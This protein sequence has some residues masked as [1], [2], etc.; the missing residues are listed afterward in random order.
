MALFLL[1]FLFSFHKS[2]HYFLFKHWF[3]NHL[4][5]YLYL[6]LSVSVHYLF[7]YG[8][9]WF[10]DYYGDFY[11]FDSLN[12]YRLLGIL[13]LFKTF[14]LS[15]QIVLVD[16]VLT[17]HSEYLSKL[18]DKFLMFFV[19][20]IHWLFK[21]NSDL[22]LTWASTGIVNA[23]ITAIGLKREVGFFQADIR[24]KH[25]K[26]RVKRLDNLLLLSYYW[27]HSIVFVNG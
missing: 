4:F 23:Y 2:F 27:N 7:N 1:F 13:L 20:L 10:F 25:E 3:F 9:D 12:E 24:F 14:Y 19:G 22:W 15:E 6:R 18:F 5:N 26:F 17:L 16:Y 8:L 11:L 21:L